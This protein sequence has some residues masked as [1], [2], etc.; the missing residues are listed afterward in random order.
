VKPEDIFSFMVILWVVCALVASSMAPVGRGGE[1]FILTLL[2][3][4]PLGLAVAM[5]LKPVGK[6]PRGRLLRLCSP[7]AARQYVPYQATSF[8]CWRCNEHVDVQPAKTRW[9]DRPLMFERRR[10]DEP[11]PSKD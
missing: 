6:A 3:L 10:G 4:G 9:G 7:C 11:K 8:D 2:L 5:L 1:F